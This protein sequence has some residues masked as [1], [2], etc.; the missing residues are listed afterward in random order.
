[1]NND[2]LAHLSNAERRKLL[3]RALQKKS[4]ALDTTHPLSLFQEGMLFLSRLQPDSVQY[5]MPHVLRLEGQLDHQALEHG[6]NELIRRHDSLRAVFDTA[7]GAPIQSIKPFQAQPLPV[8][9]LTTLSYAESVAQAQALVTSEGKRRFDLAQGP[10]LRHQL[11]RLSERES[12]LLL[13][14]HHI[15]FDL[16]SLEIFLEELAALYRAFTAGLPSSLPDLAY[17]YTNFARWQR[18][19]FQ[20]EDVQAQ[21]AYWQQKLAGPL[22]VLELPTDHPRLAEETGP[23]ARYAFEIA[24][25]VTRSINSLGRQ[26]AATSFM[27]LLAAFNV[28][29]YRYTQQDDLLVGIPCANRRRPETTHLVGLLI[30]TLVIRSDL[31]DSPSFREVVRQVKATTL[32]AFSHQDVPLMKLV[33]ILQPDRASGR[34]PIFQA[35]FALEYDTPALELPGIQ[36]TLFDSHHDTAKFDLTLMVKET[37]RGLSASFEYRT[38]LFEAAT[39]QRMAGHFEQ[40][41]SS[42]AAHPDSPIATLDILSAEE[43]AQQVLEWNATACAYSGQ[44]IHERVQAHAEADPLAI[45]AVDGDKQLSYGELNQRA[46][47]LAAY[48]RSCGVGPNTLVATCLTRSLDMLVSLVAILKA[49]GGYV[50]LDPAL[51]RERLAFLLEDSQAAL[52]LTQQPLL[53]SLPPSATSVCLDAALPE[54][55]PESTAAPRRAAPEDLAY[56]IYTSGSTGLPK[57]AQITHANLLNLISWHHQAYQMSQA[58]RCTHLA[59][60][61]FDAAAWEIWSTLAAGARLYLVDDDTRLSPRKLRDWMFVNAITVS[62]A[63]TP[64]AEEL[65]GLPW[66]ATAPLRLLLTG[67]DTLRQYPR[68]DL[69]FVLM[70]HYGPTEC[71]VLATATAVRPESHR[72]SSPPIGRPIANTQV[73]LLDRNNLL[74][75]VGVPGELHIGGAGVGVGYHRRPALTDEK[76]IINPLTGDPSDRLYK[77]GDLARYLPDGNLEYLGRID[78]QVKVRGFRIEPGEIEAALRQHEAV[79][80]AVVVARDERLVAYLVAEQAN[81][82]VFSGRREQSDS[83]LRAFLKE[84]LPEYMIPSAFVLLDAFPLT[85][86]GKIDRRVLPAPQASANATPGPIAPE[87]TT[88]TTI[89]AIWSAV[90]G[91]DRIGLNDSFFD[92][93][94]HSLLLIQVHEQLCRAFKTDL[95]LLDLFNYPTVSLLARRIGNAQASQSPARSLAVPAVEQPG[96]YDPARSDAADIAIIG[97]AGR[98]PGAQNVEAFWNNLC[99]G[100]ESISWFSRAELLEAGGDPAEIDSPNFVPA[101]GVLADADRFDAAFFGVTPREAEILDPQQRIF[102]ECA[103]EALEDGG[104]NPDRYTGRI[105]IYAGSSF[106]TYLL[107]NLYPNKDQLRMVGMYQTFIANAA[108]FLTTRIAYKL[109]LKGPAVTV[110]TAC[111][112]SLVATHMACQS[113]RSGEC[114]MALVGGV[115]IQAP[116][117]E[118]YV[119]HAGEVMSPDGHCRAFAAEAKGTVAG[120]GVG[121]VVLKPLGAALRDGDH[122]HAVI[123]GS[124]INNDG[125]LKIGYTAPSSEGQAEVIA[126]A[127]AHAG[128]HPDTVSYVETHGT[129]TVLGD[130]I[131]IEGLTKAFRS[132]GGQQTGTCAI[133]SVKTNIGHLDAAAGVTGLIKTAL[134]LKHRQIPPSLHFEQP[135]QQIDFGSSPFFVNTQLTKWQAHTHPRRA[136]VSSFGV[137]G[138]NAHVVLEEAPYQPEATNLPAWQL[139]PLSARSGSALNAATERLHDYLTHHRDARLADVAHTLQV[140]RRE[141]T[142]RRALVCRNIEDAIHALSE[143]GQRSVDNQAADGSSVVFMFPGQGAQYVDMAREVFETEPLFRDHIDHCTRLLE[144]VLGLDLRHLLFTSEAQGAAAEAQLNET[145]LTQPALFVIE[146]ALARLWQAWGVEPQA[147]IGHSIGEY[148]AACLA[149]VFSLEDALKVVAARG[150]LIQRCPAGAMLSITCSVQDRPPLPDD[151]SIAAV[152]GTHAIVVAGPSPAIDALQQRLA[153][154]GIDHRR[155]RTSHAFHSAMMND[156]L[157]SFTEQ[158]RQVTLNPPRIPFLSN[159]TGTWITAEEATDP[160]YWARHLRSAVLFADGLDRLFDAS[161]RVF[162]EVGPGVTLSTFARRHPGRGSQHT[163]LASLR[164]PREAVSDRMVLLSTVGRLWSQGLRIDWERCW[165]DQPVQ[166]VSLPTYPF[167]RQRYWIDPP[168]QR[169]PSPD[170]PLVSAARV[171]TATN[172][173][174]LAIYPDDQQASAIVAPRNDIEEF[175]AQAWQEVLGI[176]TLSVHDNFFELGGDSLMAA[177]I[178]N[179]LQELF[180]FE[181]PLN[182]IFEAPTIAGLSERIDDLLAKQLDAIEEG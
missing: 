136:G 130:P 179:R 62:F 78:Q 171:P 77:T 98:F 59:G 2:T 47:R 144:P 106:N 147:M 114:E 155:L 13:V 86:N 53:P 11:I 108:D 52:V 122:I 115:S 145:W 131:E 181:V 165:H 85:P 113:L 96:S 63:P 164:H 42:I 66:P 143:D 141:F 151:V 61:G 24:D 41:L 90:L 27:T 5:N 89:A 72:S 158:M 74:V 46:E 117:K 176:Q 21:F 23:G 31:S 99:A 148:V 139:L 69:P 118:G 28:L 137:G 138:T 95:R 174:S 8:T 160:A 121:V 76:F 12:W 48:M 14:V 32:E 182:S 68:S 127:L 80:D 124:A 81:Q 88:E 82:R 64:L 35:M 180:L 178:T 150:R 50:P 57:G 91:K 175:V 159:L 126:Q 40:L 7:D 38:T 6:M 16:V 84:R 20:G 134:A 132:Q 79:R 83:E 49:G 65:I 26:E 105:G 71:T 29:L 51:P 34:T 30:N 167:E 33:E 3:M 172:S 157:E 1:M 22:P 87:Q 128:V 109:G 67:G 17:T 123:K 104:Y 133:G 92:L 177:R 93:G 149:G 70:N 103:W 44:L 25:S 110:Q 146:Y 135:N 19:W 119:Y 15:I 170:A 100:V 116:L 125:A 94:G 4:G 129:G 102:L 169:E 45:A 73:Y 111:S 107:N 120:T 54:F 10:L 168:Q 162:L 153:D 163:I 18:Q 39:I 43:I 166:R 60:L 156:I 152:N 75:P 37:E 56:V 101:K 36:A 161:R 154:Q 140:G 55:D 58:D 112:T 142:H 9:D 97:M 173:D